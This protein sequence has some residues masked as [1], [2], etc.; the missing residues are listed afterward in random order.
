MRN[1]RVE[2]QKEI[3]INWRMTWSL[4]YELIGLLLWHLARGDVCNDRKSY[5]FV[6]Y[7]V[8]FGTKLDVNL[9]MNITGWCNSV[10]CAGLFWMTSLN[11]SRRGWFI[12]MSFTLSSPG[13]NRSAFLPHACWY[14]KLVRRLETQPYRRHDAVRLYVIRQLG[15]I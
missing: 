6:L 1:Q 14:I 10:R 11:S 15:F 5:I 8:N 12:S 4:F 3:T 7:I 13:V 2:K 9:P